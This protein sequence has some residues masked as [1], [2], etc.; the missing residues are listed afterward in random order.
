M[1]GCTLV[2]VQPASNRQG[3]FSPF[4]GC[5]SGGSFLRTALLSAVLI[6]HSLFFVCSIGLSVTLPTGTRPLSACPLPVRDHL[7]K[8][9]RNSALFE[10]G[11]ISSIPSPPDGHC[12]LHSVC[13]SWRQ[14]LSGTNILQSCAI[15]FLWT[16]LAIGI[17]ISLFCRHQQQ[18]ISLQ[19]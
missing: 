15:L 19:V 18:S 16:P 2:I 17:L 9:G 5:S 7:G 12:L 10:P 3:L 6:L 13:E 14:Q 1:G 8:W 11:D 4:V